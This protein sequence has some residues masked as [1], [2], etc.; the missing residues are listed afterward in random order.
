MTQD[1]RKPLDGIRVVDLTRVLSGPFCSMLLGD[2]GAEVIK[3]EPPEGGDPV[4]QQGGMQDGLSWYFASFNRNKKSVTLNL[5]DAGDMALLRQLI[6][7]A[8]VLVEN[9]R[10]G[11]LDKM[12]LDA[13]T[14]E[15]L[16]PRLVTCSINGFGSSGPYADR[17]AFDFITQ[18]MSGFMSVNGGADQPP[19]RSGQPITDLLAGLYAAYG[20]VNALRARELNGRGQQVESAMMNGI[21]SF[22]AYLA[23]EHLL[24]GEIPARTGND[25][26]LVAPY[27]LFRARDGEV[28]V[29]ASND[30]VL[31][32]FMRCLELEHLLEDPRFD[33]NAK[34][35]ARRNELNTL[36]DG[37]M[38]QDTQAAW[39]ERLNAAGVPSGRVQNLAEALRDPQVMAQE[40]VIDVPHPGR[41]A[42]RMLGFPVKLSET[43]C[44]AHLPAPELGQH[45]DEILGPLRGLQGQS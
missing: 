7:G 21:L 4:R 14:L 15:Q 36:I 5:R 44:E 27:G 37:R 11:V 40:M 17:P 33:E 6:E 42:V 34:R 12:G 13:T 38:V 45:N 10:P 22:M 1:L 26:P 31:R 20:A 39:I 43:P 41:G 19:L 23:S 16:N 8:D 9:Y 29:A 35:T 18:A 28:A 2:M 3:V 24:T 25:H 32:R 30:M